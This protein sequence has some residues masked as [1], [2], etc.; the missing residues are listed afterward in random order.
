MDVL[1][2]EQ[3]VLIQRTAGEFLAAECPPSLVRAVEKSEE[4]YSKQLWTKFADL[5]WLGLCL[6]E[7]RGGQGLPLTYL[8]LVLE[9]VGRYLAPLPV[10][11]TMAPAL[12]IASFGTQVQKQ[13]IER[14]ACGELLLSFAIEERS[15]R[16]STDA[17]ALSGRR[18]GDDIVLN[19]S[20]YFVDNFRVAQ[21]CMVAVRMFGADGG[22]EGPAAVLVDTASAGIHCEALLTTAKDG[23][24][25]V[26]F[27]HVRVPQSNRVGAPR[28]G[29][30]VI[31]ALMDYA[32]VFLVSQMQGA[33]RQAME[34]AVE[35]VKHR[36]A[37]GQPIGAFQAIQHMA[38]DMVNAV[39]GTQLLGREAVWRMSQG[40]PARVEVSQAKSFANEKCMMVCRSAQQ[41][42]G[43]IGFIA[44]FDLNLW[45][46]R[47]TSW[48]LRGGTTY[49][50][51]A[52][53]ASALLDTPGEVRLGRALEL[54]VAGPN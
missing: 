7:E 25:V 42:H 36:E 40:L 27:D 24:S 38:A 35:Y 21:K 28:Q 48:T 12:V 47:V 45:Y 34:F 32:S 41:M 49:E 50:H 3:E 5:G 16:W 39:D 18:D 23:E 6:P 52:R 20:K 30:A 33:A 15:G 17:I 51:R 31:D 4:K 11:S 26:R 13:L 22:D 54:P 46:R 1:S 2:D 29:R 44:E 19:G 43:G 37:F 10:H 8:G 14:V 53:I 9:E